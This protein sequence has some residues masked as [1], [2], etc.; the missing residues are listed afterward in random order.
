MLGTASVTFVPHYLPR[1]GPRVFVDLSEPILN[2][3]PEQLRLFADAAKLA[4]CEAE[5]LEHR[6]RRKKACL[7]RAAGT[8]LEETH[9][10]ARGGPAPSTQGA[11]SEPRIP[12]L[13]S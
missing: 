6:A 4:S 7:L 2:L 10:T 8:R 5:A 13:P 3:T 11:T 9:N 12:L 1:V